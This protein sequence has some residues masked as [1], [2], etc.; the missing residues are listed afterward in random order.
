MPFGH[1]QYFCGGFQTSVQLWKKN[2]H[3]YVRQEAKTGKKRKLN[4]RPICNLKIQTSGIFMQLAIA[5]L[6]W[7]RNLDTP[8][9]LPDFFCSIR[10]T[11]SP[12]RNLAGEGFLSRNHNK[13]WVSWMTIW[14]A[15]A[16]FSTLQKALY[17]WCG[18]NQKEFLLVLGSQMLKQQKGFFVACMIFRDIITIADGLMIAFRAF[19]RSVSNYF[20]SFRIT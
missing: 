19:S 11:W 13:N 4:T 17:N 9:I 20:T 14:V 7:D 10:E 1:T 6:F 2:R 18:Q 15:T 8:A 12:R 5:R 3:R 16:E